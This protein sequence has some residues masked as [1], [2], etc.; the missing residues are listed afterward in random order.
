MVTNKVGQGRAASANT[1]PLD[2][3]TARNNRLDDLLAVQMLFLLY[4]IIIKKNT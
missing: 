1:R 3:L 2:L 4:K